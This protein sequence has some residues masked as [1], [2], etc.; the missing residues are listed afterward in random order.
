MLIQR[1]A[2]LYE[3]VR[4]YEQWRISELRLY[5]MCRTLMLDD[6]S[7]TLQTPPL[8][9]SGCY[10]LAVLVSVCV[11]LNKISH[12]K[13]V[14]LISLAFRHVLSVYW[15]VFL[16]SVPTKDGALGICEFFVAAV[17]AAIVY[18]FLGGG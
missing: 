17:V 11:F 6:T 9:M 5:P 14:N 4:R 15:S 1:L 12:N 16:V 2:L 13:L 3:T 18:E 8:L 10:A 7:N